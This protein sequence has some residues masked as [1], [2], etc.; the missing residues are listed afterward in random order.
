LRRNDDKNI[1]PPSIC[2]SPFPTRRSEARSGDDEKRQCVILCD[3]TRD[4]R[5]VLPRSEEALVIVLARRSPRSKNARLVRLREQSTTS[6][7]TSAAHDDIAAHAFD[8]P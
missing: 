5:A 1:S 4:L 3:Q 2:V 6:V 7:A 8:E